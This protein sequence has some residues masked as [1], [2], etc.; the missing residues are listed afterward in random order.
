[1]YQASECDKKVPEEV[2]DR[3]FKVLK[4]DDFR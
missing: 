4:L 2:N 3:L 1:M